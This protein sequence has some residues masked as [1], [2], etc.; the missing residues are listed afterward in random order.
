MRK[1]VIA[2]LLV[3]GTVGYAGADVI[4]DNGGPDST[5]IYFSDFQGNG[6]FAAETFE[7][8]PGATTLAD[9]HWYGGYFPD[10]VA[11]V[12]DDF[13]IG[14]YGPGGVEVFAQSVG[15]VNR[16]NTGLV[17][18]DGL[19]I[20]EYGLDIAPVNL[21]ANTNYFM[22][23]INNTIEPNQ[24]GWS[25]SGPGEHWQLYEQDGFW[26]PV[27]SELAF[28]LTGP[29]VVPEPAS[30]SLLVIGLAGMALRRKVTKK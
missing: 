25:I 5:F 23:I 19:D 30:M 15:A 20:W 3:M 2:L 13:Y 7:L 27:D 21:Q 8:Q 22:T 14:I 24:W 26:V 9:I 4:Y 28:Y 6:F 10:N 16:V 18:L 29:S 12:A 11:P 1:L 17:G